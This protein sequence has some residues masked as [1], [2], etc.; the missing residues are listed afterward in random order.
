M[1]SGPN[2]IPQDY[3]DSHIPLLSPWRESCVQ[4]GLGASVATIDKMI[5]LLCDTTTTLEQWAKLTDELTGRLSDEM[6]QHFYLSLTPIETLRLSNPAPFG[7]EV[8]MAF[9]EAVNDIDEA[10]KCLALGR[11]TACVFHSMR[12]LEF[13]L[14]ALATALNVP[15]PEKSWHTVI[16]DIQ[17]AVKTRRDRGPGKGT[18]EEEDPNWETL[19]QFYAE[20]VV[21]F[22]FLK[23]A[24]RNRTA[25]IGTNY[26]MEKA[27]S[28]F[29]HSGEFMRHLATRL[30]EQ[31][32]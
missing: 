26:S 31:A 17:K 5:A 9:A 13:G 21:H 14:V 15:D 30:G 8:P 24:W 4:I 11:A 32:S 25:H 12:V 16:V 3:R 20:A 1:A 7:D 22:E 28:V 19:T 2:I 6:R 23:D 10:S 29:Q 27:E 18:A